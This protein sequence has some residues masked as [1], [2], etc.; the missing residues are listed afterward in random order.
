MKSTWKLGSM[1]REQTPVSASTTSVWTPLTRQATKS[2][3]AIEAT[4]E[5]ANTVEN[6]IFFKVVSESKGEVE[7]D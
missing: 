2:A 3:D 4:A 5:A 7:V 6:F 1:V